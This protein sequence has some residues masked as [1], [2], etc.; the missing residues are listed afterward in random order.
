MHLTQEVPAKAEHA[1][2]H[3]DE[4]KD[5]RGNSFVLL[6]SG[7]ACGARSLLPA[8]RC[9]G[10]SASPQPTYPVRVRAGV[11]AEAE[12]QDRAGEEAKQ[13]CRQEPGT[14]HQAPVNLLTLRGEI[15]A[16]CVGAEKGLF[17]PCDSL[18]REFSVLHIFH[19]TSA[20]LL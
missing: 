10:R 1:L 2:A 19:E 16:A 15:L 17:Q 14:F 3:G 13:R 4:I 9:F 18:R 11:G 8:G 20:A 12:K 7:L 5:V 6:R